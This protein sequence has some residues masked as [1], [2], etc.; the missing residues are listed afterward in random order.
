[1]TPPPSFNN[2]TTIH[3]RPRIKIINRQKWPA[4]YKDPSPSTS[5][6]EDEDEDDVLPVLPKKHIFLPQATTNGIS[7]IIV[8]GIRMPDCHPDNDVPRNLTYSGGCNRPQTSIYGFGDTLC[9]GHGTETAP[10]THD[11]NGV[12]TITIDRDR[13][14]DYLSGDA[15]VEHGLDTTGWEFQIFDDGGEYSLNQGDNHYQL[16]PGNVLVFRG[17]RS[18]QPGYEPA[19]GAQSKRGQADEFDGMGWV[20]VKEEV[21]PSGEGKREP[22]VG[23]GSSGSSSSATLIDAY[24]NMNKG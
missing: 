16:G 7:E 3:K 21:P 6:S 15:L 24:A 12:A 8:A 20:L 2:P 4:T 19:D 18:F 23:D 5:G 14:Q 17:R 22:E 9:L 10:L 11:H 13:L 1:M